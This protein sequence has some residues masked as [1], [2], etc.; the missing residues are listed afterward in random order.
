MRASKLYIYSKLNKSLRDWKNGE[1]SWCIHY[2]LKDLFKW[3]HANGIIEARLAQGGIR[4]A[5]ICF[6]SFSV[7]QRNIVKG[8]RKQ[9]SLGKHYKW[10]END[11]V[12]I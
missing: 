5:L 2:I 11:V 4:A 8:E 12:K 6:H 7:I 10:I 9:R 3:R 1:N